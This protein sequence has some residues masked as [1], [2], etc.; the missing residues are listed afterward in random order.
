MMKEYVVM[1]LMLVPFAAAENQSVENISLSIENLSL[2]CAKQFECQKSGQ[3]YWFD[4]KYDTE[5]SDCRCFLGEF[6]KCDLSRSTVVIAASNESVPKAPFW[7]TTLAVA[8]DYSGK[9]ANLAVNASIRAKIMA[10]AALAL[11]VALVYFSTRDSSGKDLKR[12]VHYHKLAEK[13]YE[14]GDLEKSKEYYELSNYHREKA[15][16]N[17]E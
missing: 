16:E 15:H 17:E 9:A 11:L 13:S 6:S 8:K 7:I 2:D 14:K 4:C 10:L 12:A 1:M 3:S 5:T